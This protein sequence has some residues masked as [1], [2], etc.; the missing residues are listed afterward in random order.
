MKKIIL[1]SKPFA[2]FVPGPIK[3]GRKPVE[4]FIATSNNNNATKTFIFNEDNY[5]I[6]LIKLILIEVIKLS[7]Y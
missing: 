3:P 1:F 2:P 6:I 7:D 5:P 4:T